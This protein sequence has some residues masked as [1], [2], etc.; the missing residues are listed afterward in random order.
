MRNTTLSCN[1]RF[2]GSHLLPPPPYPLWFIRFCPTFFSTISSS[3]SGCGRFPL[4][5][6]SIAPIQ[7]HKPSPSKSKMRIKSEKSE[8]PVHDQKNP[9]LG[10]V[11]TTPELQHLWPIF[12]SLR[13]FGASSSSFDG[14]ASCPSEYL[15]H[16]IYKDQ[17]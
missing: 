12:A 17:V 3:Y 2:G 1:V 15:L 9:G 7:L 14:S 8:K 10:L 16:S 11:R 5:P 6:Q 13:G 4:Q